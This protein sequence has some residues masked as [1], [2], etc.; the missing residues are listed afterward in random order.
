[1]KPAFKYT[2]QRNDVNDAVFLRTSG[3]THEVFDSEGQFARFFD[4]INGQHTLPQLAEL[5]GLTE[6]EVNEIIQQLDN[7]YLLE[8]SETK[9]NSLSPYDASRWA[10]NLNFLG[11]YCKLDQNKFELQE[12]LA[13]AHVLILGL[14]G[15]GSHLLYDLAAL[16][17]KKITAVEFDNVEISNL[18]RQI[19]YTENDIGQRKSDIAKKR[20]LEFSPQLEF[21]VVQKQL[22]CYEDLNEIATANEFDIVICVADRPKMYI[23]EWVNKVCVQHAIPA[24]FGGL[25]TQKA[26]FFSIIPNDS[27]CIACWRKNIEKT[28]P[29]SE[30][31]YS[32]QRV[33][34]LRGDN[35]AFVPF[36]ALVGGYIVAEVAK[37]ITGFAPPASVGKCL[38]FD[39]VDFKLSE[40]ETW[41]RTD[42]CEVCS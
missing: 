2:V 32:H 18:N 41:E 31:L 23:H 17:I 5:S 4:L 26:R 39:L 11:S 13:N 14:G 25:D 10:R 1:M 21:N 16:G 19:L 30:Q 3:I 15:L 35:A 22:R 29:I 33:N 20:I 28:D 7:L 12:K 27:G 37:M 8:D 42:A 40:R 6:K 36:V 38:E 24:L 34:E 9:P